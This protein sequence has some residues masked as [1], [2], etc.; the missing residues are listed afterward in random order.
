M[1]SVHRSAEPDFF[2]D[3]RA[4]FSRW[5]DLE[6]CVRQR[7]R[8]VL[9]EDFNQCCAY[10]ERRC[11]ESGGESADRG[12]VDHFRPRSRF[13]EKWLFW[14]NLAYSCRRCN[15]TKGNLWP[16]VSDA[17]NR[18]LSVISRFGPVSTYIDP[19][20]VDGQRDVQELFEYYFE[21]DNRGQVIPSEHALPEEWSMAYR[22][23]EDLDLNSDYERVDTRLPELR[24]DQLDYILEEIGDPVVD[25]DRTVAV[26]REYSQ[27]HQPFSSYIAAYAKFLEI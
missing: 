24:T 13:P 22:T 11:L 19:S 8:A 1:H 3:L 23:I 16:E 21:D 20:A 27:P 25:L 10:C 4:S 17:T 6:G 7:I 5:E 2:P 9:R 14:P 26:L 15:D 18:R 12:T